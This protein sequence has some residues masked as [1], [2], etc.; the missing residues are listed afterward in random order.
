[1]K[2]SYAMGARL[3][4]N[5][6]GL[7]TPLGANVLETV[8]GLRTGCKSG[9]ITKYDIL[10]GRSVV[11]GMA[12]NNLPELKQEFLSFDCRNNRLVLS[13]LNQIEETIALIIARY[14]RE[15]IAVV[16]GTSTSGIASTE[17]AFATY[18]KTN[19]WP[20]DFDYQ[21]QEI[22]GL[23]RFVA[24]YIGVNGPAYTVATACSSSAKVFASA[25]RLIRSGLA[26]AVIVGGADTAC[27]MTING[28]NALELLSKTECNPFSRNRDGITIGEG[29]A[30]FVMSKEESP[31]E[32][33]GVGETSDAYHQTSPEP[34]GKGA[35][36]AMRQALDNAGLVPEDIC[37]IN[38]H[39]TATRQNDAMESRAVN[40]VFGG[41]TPC[42]STKSLTGHMLG[43][44]GAC[45]AA[46]LWA[47]IHPD[48]TS[49]FLPPH[50]W[51]GVKDEDM[52][53]LN[54]I[55]VNRPVNRTG[56]I[57]MLSNSFGFGGSNA[58]LILGRRS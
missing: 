12:E 49:G 31:V 39:G 6:C 34:D 3:Y 27:R 41:D 23:S 30:I 2:D 58:A 14:G 1:M 53:N 55:P 47:A 8:S 54:L 38:L 48:I 46:F 21:K 36:G 35:Q 43:A 4:L 19:L 32:L 29:A 42:S 15:R 28:F 40:A 24:T 10:S 13:C 17:S 45:E 51:D 33:M 22:G 57:A 25:Q 56:A 5:A 16:M 37:Y 9:L 11:V 7:N 44:A 26:D 50:I 20:N 18:K 52:P